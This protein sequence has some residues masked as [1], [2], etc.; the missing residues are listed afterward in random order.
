MTSLVSVAIPVA[1]FTRNCL[2][3]HCRYSSTHLGYK[4]FPCRYSETFII[5]E[6]VRVS[7]FFLYNCCFDLVFKI[8]GICCFL[9]TLNFILHSYCMKDS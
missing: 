3:G 4:M 2:F 7:G 6:S 5:P 9:T 8:S 1:D